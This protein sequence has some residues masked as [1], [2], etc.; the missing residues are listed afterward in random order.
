LAELHRRRFC[1]VDVWRLCARK[2]KLY[3][4]VSQPR[5]RGPG[6]DALKTGNPGQKKTAGFAFPM[7]AH[8][9]M[10]GEASASI[11]T[12][13][14]N[15]K[16]MRFNLLHCGCSRKGKNSQHINMQIDRTCQQVYTETATA[17][18]NTVNISNCHISMQT[19][20]DLCQHFDQTLFGLTTEYDMT[21]VCKAYRAGFVWNQRYYSRSSSNKA[22]LKTRRL[23]HRSC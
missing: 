2:G 15:V 9:R 18:E 16:C 22:N 20:D 8:R 14:M 17:N 6:F 23:R 10:M 7:R 12:S 19:E 1:S 5:T 4:V 3:I 21:T 13:A 11:A